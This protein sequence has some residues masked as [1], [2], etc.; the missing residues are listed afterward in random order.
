MNENI[1]ILATMA[2]AETARVDMMFDYASTA[3]AM[4]MGVL[5]FLSLDSVLIFKSG[6][7]EKLASTTRDKIEKALALGVK[8]VACAAAK[9]GFGVKDFGIEG[10]EVW[11]AGSFF[12]YA[13]SA[14]ATLT[15]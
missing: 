2:P 13:A 10:I 14:R 9:D 3:S 12:N 7:Y 15:L 8:V 4:G 11:G 6:V 1:A 5:V